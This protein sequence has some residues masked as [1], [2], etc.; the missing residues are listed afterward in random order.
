M[1]RRPSTQLAQHALVQDVLT[2]LQL[3]PAAPLDHIAV[4]VSASRSSIQRAFHVR[5]T[6]FT[7]EQT[8]MRLDRAAWLLIEQSGR[9]QH[10]A[11][12]NA[13]NATGGWRPRHLCKPCRDRYGVTPGRI[14]SIGCAIRGLRGLANTPSP[15]SRKDPAAYARRRRRIIQ[16]R[17]KLKIAQRELLPGTIVVERV[18]EALALELNSTPR[19][20]RPEKRRARPRAR[21]RRGG[22]R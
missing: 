16:L 4:R 3:K 14:W 13:A 8:G 9:S 20:A 2:V 7:A 6:S 21:A 17:Y 15:H 5:G 11:L 1:A 12:I 18:A 10:V 19:G 22:R